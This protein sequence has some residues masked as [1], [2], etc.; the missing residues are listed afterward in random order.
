M[1]LRRFIRTGLWA[2]LW[3]WATL[4]R[5]WSTSRGE[6]RPRQGGG[7]CAE[8]AV[9]R[10]IFAGGFS[11]SAAADQEAGLDESI[12]KMLPSVGPFAGMQQMAG[13]VDE[14]QLTR[15]EAIIN[16]MT[17]KER[18]HHEIINGKPAEADRG[19]SGTTVQDVNQLLRQYAQM[20][21]MFKR[22]GRRAMGMGGGR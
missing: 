12:M 16:S 2:G 6:A 9:G 17:Q 8:G 1:R 21:K 11:R 5:C 3:A 19:G 15:V 20:R 10:W 7:V 22:D 4:P 18:D 14:K 13:Q